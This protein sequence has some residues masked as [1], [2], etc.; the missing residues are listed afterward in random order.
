MDILAA[1]KKAA[2]QSKTFK[3][4]ETEAKQPA[5]VHQVSELAQQPVE[6]KDLPGPASPPSAPA[7]PVAEAPAPG[8][9]APAACDAAGGMASPGDGPDATPAQEIELLSF[10]LRGEEYAVMVDDV[11]EVLR[12]RDLTLLPNV[13]DYILGVTSLRGTILPVIDLGRRLGLAA[14]ERDEKSR[15]VV[16]SI[17]DERMGLHVDRVTGVFRVMPDEVKP[18]PENIDQGEEFLS[19]IVRKEDKLYILLDLEKAAGI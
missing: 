15:I 7:V 10:L 4:Q 5:L 11:R 13:P 3:Q 18:P 19:G 1:R 8:D 2:E 9:T 14:G 16:V 17:D 12:V 6:T